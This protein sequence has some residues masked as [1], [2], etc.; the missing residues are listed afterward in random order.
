M[1]SISP[2]LS[3]SIPGTSGSTIAPLFSENEKR[4]H[5][6]NAPLTYLITSECCNAIGPR[7]DTS[8]ADPFPIRPLCCPNAA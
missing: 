7:P 5:P 2:L 8:S 1:S 3:I 4:S 6:E